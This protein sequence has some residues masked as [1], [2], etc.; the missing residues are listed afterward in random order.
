MYDPA[1]EPFTEQVHLPDDTD[2]VD[3][4]RCMLLEFFFLR[5]FF[6]S[7]DDESDPDGEGDGGA[8][9]TDSLAD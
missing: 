7:S 5:S 8:I 6:S 2:D 4:Q 9:A 1:K 3:Q